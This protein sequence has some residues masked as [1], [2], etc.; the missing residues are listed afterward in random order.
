MMLI[1]M[2]MILKPLFMSNIWLGV[3]DLNN[4]KHLKKDAYKELIPV[5]QRVTRWCD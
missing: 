3:V 2:K 4:L 1:F 5:A